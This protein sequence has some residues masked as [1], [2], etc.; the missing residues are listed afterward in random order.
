MDR[1]GRI[2]G[3]LDIPQAAAH[4]GITF[5]KQLNMQVTNEASGGGQALPQNCHEIETMDIYDAPFGLRARFQ[6]ITKAA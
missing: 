3:S 6:R 5:D 4:E 2:F 1:A